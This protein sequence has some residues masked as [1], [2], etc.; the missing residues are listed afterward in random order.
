[1]SAMRLDSASTAAAVTPP[2][3]AAP[4]VSKP[5]SQLVQS[6]TFENAPI[7]AGLAL[8]AAGVNRN[9][10]FLPWNFHWTFLNTTQ[11]F[12]H[13]EV[14]R[15]TGPMRKLVAA[16]RPL[17][18]VQFT[19]AQGKTKP[20]ADLLNRGDMDGFMVLHKGQVVQETLKEG[21]AP[22]QNHWTLSLCRTMTGIVAGK[23]V[24]QGLLSWDQP[25]EKVIPELAHGGFAGVT[26]R[27]LIDM[28][29]GV[30]STNIL[31]LM[32]ADGFF[33]N[34]PFPAPAGV[35]DH[36]ARRTERQNPHG[37]KFLYRCLDT[38]V[39]GWLCERA[40]GKRLPSLISEMIWQPMGAEKSAQFL[41]DRA[42]DPTYGSGLCANLRDLARFGQVL[43]E[44][45]KPGTR[46]ILPQGWMQDARRGTAD[47]RAAFGGKF[48]DIPLPKG[49]YRNHMWVL[50]VDRGTTLCFGAFGQMIYVDPTR[51]L[52][53]VVL[54]TWGTPQDKVT[55]DWL[56]AFEAI[57]AHCATPPSQSTKALC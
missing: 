19:N 27:Q 52:V 23:L 37:G 32:W 8:R 48:F 56:R 41:T 15:G 4:P 51:E 42:G 54:N 5:L 18:D 13:L 38:E 6:D 12:P 16:P 35:H 14:P 36:I 55:A 17:R 26:L 29:S 49:M 20:L 7:A 43:A 46:Q 1:M 30:T 11:L 28:R 44:D 10:W 25:V 45:G 57:G 47:S 9:N 31:R 39:L 40:S 22:L 33:P 2:V 3:G 24:E 50:D 34:G 21:V 53:C